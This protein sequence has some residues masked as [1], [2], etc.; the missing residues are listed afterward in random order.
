MML[1]SVFSFLLAVLVPATSFGAVQLADF[2][3]QP[4]FNTAGVEIRLM[5]ND[6][7]G[8]QLNTWGNGT[9]GG[10]FRVETRVGGT[11]HTIVYPPAATPNAEWILKTFCM[12]RGE[13]ISLGATYIA[14]IDEEAY[15]GKNL[16]D[17]NSVS[18]EPLLDASRLLYGLYAEG[19]LATESG[20]FQY[21]NNHWA[22]A[23]QRALWDLED[24]IS[25]SGDA[26]SLVNWA[27]N[28]L[29]LLDSLSG[30]VAVLNTWKGETYELA[31]ARQS[32]FLYIP[33]SEEVPEPAS[34]AI[35]SALGLIGMIAAGRRRRRLAT[36]ES[37]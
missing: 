9:G 15:Y 33:N 16:R 17:A 3:S 18:P 22:D 8:G 31:S 28:N 11:W 6:I 13:F 12:E 37:S 26:F 20:L 2:A 30:H 24:N 14:T 29:T 7:G 4:N 23:L 25:T 34:V 5:G 1:R 35:W 27:N 36:N 21:E 10:E 32:Q 19:R